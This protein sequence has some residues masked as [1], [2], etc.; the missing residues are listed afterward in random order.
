MPGLN[1]HQ[2]IRCS[3]FALGAAVCLLETVSALADEK[4]FDYLNT[5]SSHVTTFVSDAETVEVSKLT[6][7]PSVSSKVLI[8]FSSTVSAESADG[9][10]CSVRAMVSM[11]G[12][13]PRIVK[14]INV[15]SPAVVSLQKYPFDR[16]ALDGSS[17]F[18]V[19]PGKHTFSILFK[20]VSGSSKKLEINYPNAQAMVFGN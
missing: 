3:V 20:Q 10:P 15:G 16:Q 4:T 5:T 19:T 7:E 12:G 9:C 2:R 6:V 13:E 1:R 8:Q 17:V 18:E 11:D 14:R